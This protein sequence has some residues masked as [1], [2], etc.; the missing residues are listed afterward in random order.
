MT[1]RDTQSS[2][3]ICCGRPMSTISVTSGLAQ[4]S[5]TLALHTCASCGHH[6]WERDGG[7]VAPDKVLDAVKARVAEGPLPRASSTRKP[8]DRR[9]SPTPRAVPPPR[10]PD[11]VQER[12]KGFRP[13]GS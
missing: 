9:A 6:V 7:E 8:K 4:P 11:D 12:L 1:T 10:V 2:L 5:S 3:A 13:H